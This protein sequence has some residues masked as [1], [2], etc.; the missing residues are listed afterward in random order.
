ML[1]GDEE[2]IERLL[3]FL[4]NTFPKLDFD[5]KIPLKRLFPEPEAI[6]LKR[7]WRRAHGDIVIFRHGKLC[8]IL[9]IGGRAHFSDEKQKV[10][11]GKKDR[12]CKL[13]KVGC[14]RVGN[15]FLNDMEKI[16]GKRLLRKAF[17]SV[18]R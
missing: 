15:S 2:V 8:C 9:E 7:F 3:I 5:Q 18:V 12:L 17:Y 6:Y 1:Q 10:R 4:R 14:L 13:N 16:A 11:D